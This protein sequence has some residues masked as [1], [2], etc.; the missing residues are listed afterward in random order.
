MDIVGLKRPQLLQLC[1]E[2]GIHRVSKKKKSELVIL[3]TDF[4]RNYV[5]EH[6]TRMQQLM[7]QLLLV[8]KKD[9]IRKVCSQCWNLGHYSKSVDCPINQEK[10][11]KWKDK[12]ELY[13]LEVDCLEP[14]DE[15]IDALASQLEISTNLCKTLYSEINPENLLERP[16]NLEKYFTTL[17]KE[18]CSNCSTSIYTAMESSIKTWQSQK[19]CDKCWCNLKPVRDYIWYQIANYKPMIC[20]ICGK[21]QT[22]REERFHYDHINMFNK[23][24]NV[25]SM[26]NNGEAID[27]IYKEIDKC[28]ILCYHCHTIITDLEQKI[29]FTRI[30]RLLTQKTNQNAISTEE[31]KEKTEQYE[32]MYEKKVQTLYGKISSKLVG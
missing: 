13:F 21:K 11:R 31:K 2:Y 5:T 27:A 1:Q 19:I 4:Q 17:T 6:K 15:H 12:V 10:R 29:G 9:T 3:L 8:V 22:N 24:D 14:I 26:V 7:E 25:C 23:S 28:Q 18:N 20:R 32:T 16:I 30:K